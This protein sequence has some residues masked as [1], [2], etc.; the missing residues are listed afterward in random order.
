MGSAAT[1]LL[2]TPVDFYKQDKFI[3]L[4]DYRDELHEDFM[5]LFAS[6]VLADSVTTPFAREG[7]S[8]IIV[9]KGPSAAARKQWGDRYEEKRQ[10][11]SVF[12]GK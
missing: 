12:N 8:I 9:M 5:K 2:W 4:T 6:T 11:I 7:G 3:L 10:K 1:Y